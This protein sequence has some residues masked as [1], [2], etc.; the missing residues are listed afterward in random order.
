MTP[1]KRWPNHAEWARLDV[2]GLSRRIQ[3]RTKEAQAAIE[4]NNR[5][6][7]A[8]LLADI[9]A[10]AAEII[11]ILVN[12]K[13]GQGPMAGQDSIERLK[14]QNE[15]LERKLKEARDLAERLERAVKATNTT[16]QDG[17]QGGKK[18]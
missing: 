7:A 4:R 16:K 9:R 5:L 6:L 13:G 3:D 2:I 14:R 12:V 15:E 1:S 10:D 8:A 17:Q 18:R 11:T